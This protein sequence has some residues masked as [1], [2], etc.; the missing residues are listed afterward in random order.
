MNFTEDEWAVG[1][2]YSADSPCGCTILVEPQRLQ[3]WGGA[4][5]GIEFPGWEV[6]FTPCE[7][8]GSWDGDLRALTNDLM[9]KAILDGQA[10]D[11]ALATLIEEIEI[12]LGDAA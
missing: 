8:H 7:T 3:A 9:Q 1:D 11:A 12:K 5:D 4:Q 6:G 10:L 2:R